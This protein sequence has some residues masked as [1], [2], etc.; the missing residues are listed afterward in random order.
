MMQVAIEMLKSNYSVQD[1]SMIT[2]LSVE[3][4]IVLKSKLKQ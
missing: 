3:Q 1:I 2:K 4:I